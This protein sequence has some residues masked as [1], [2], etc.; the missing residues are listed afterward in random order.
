LVG[1][2]FSEVMSLL[3]VAWM[4]QVVG[5]FSVGFVAGEGDSPARPAVKN[6]RAIEV[7]VTAKHLD[8]FDRPDNRGFVTGLARRGE[9]LR[10]R[11]DQPV[12]TGWLAIDPLP[13]SI[14]WVQ[15]S[16]LELE[17]DGASWAIRNDAEPGARDRGPLIRAWVSR[18]PAIVRSG[19][20]L[21]R[22]PG[23]PNG[24]LPACTLVQL[25][26]RPAL[27]LGQEGK[28]VRWLAIVPPPE[29]AFFIHAD[30]IRWPAPSAPM[31][32]AAEVRA[33]YEEPAHSPEQAIPVG[34][35]PTG[36]TS[37]WPPEVLAEIDRL[38]GI[39]RVIVSSQPIAQWRFE[40][41]R[42][43]YQNLLKRAGDRADLE[44]ALRA[45][46]A[47]LTQHEQAARAARTIESI[48]AKSH[49][50]D[51]EVSAARRQFARLERTRAREF[52][53]VGF[54][55]PSAR[56]VDGHKVFALIGREG[57]TDAYLDIPPGLDPEPFLASRVGVRGQAHFNEDLGTRLISVRDLESIE[58]KK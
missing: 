9:R 58:K 20:L 50:R 36:S 37:S 47:R 13:T 8:V 22:L 54:I 2:S 16:S 10:V 4:I 24:S 7:D 52:D 18:E 27:E 39:F 43:G 51:V 33:S 40:T 41:L 19:N 49:R 29:Q 26:D 55:Q 42:A 34:K 53:A 57:K 30:G 45:R 25:V 31:P 12:G 23:P 48:L 46:L 5:L 44:N 28:N 14:L 56:M 21:A 15:E 17:D 6:H 11:I 38:D 3:R 32:A 1:P 35:N